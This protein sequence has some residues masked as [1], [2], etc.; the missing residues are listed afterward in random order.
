M[1]HGEH[2]RR[3]V[4]AFE[5]AA[6]R[7]DGAVRVPSCPDWSMTDLVLHLGRVHR[8]LIGLLEAGLSHPPNP[9]DFTAEQPPV[10]GIVDWFADGARTLAVLFADRDPGEPVWTWSAEQTVGFWV[11]MQSIEA[12]VHRWD[13]ENALGAT[14][15]IDTELA[16]DAVTQTFQVMAPARRAWLH[17]PAGTGE[18]FGF[19]QT[20]GSHAWTVRFDGTDVV[21]TEDAGPADVEL[22]GTASD[23]ALFLWHR[24]PADGM[25]VAG[26]PAALDRYFTL[27][28][29]G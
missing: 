19:R 4:R 17:A 16:E 7:A 22:A 18:T 24:I 3:E 5:A 14:L 29:P 6:R 8:M 26:D 12:A 11:R 25:R 21:L 23:L 27:V 28:P 20:D 13:A 1:D 10:D 15:P 2:F 9:A